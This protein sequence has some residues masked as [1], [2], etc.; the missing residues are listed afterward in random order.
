MEFALGA[1]YFL[2]PLYVESFAWQL[3]IG[4]YRRSTHLAIGFS[5]PKVLALLFA[6]VTIDRENGSLSQL[7]PIFGAD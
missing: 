4:L 1:Q 3:L 2:G 7:L 5:S 6:S